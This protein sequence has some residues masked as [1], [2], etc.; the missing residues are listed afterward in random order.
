L[1]IL[2]A[3][4]IT[5]VYRT[6]GRH[7]ERIA[8]YREFIRLKTDDVEAYNNVAW[9]LAT[10]PDPKFRDSAQAVELARQAVKLA[11]SS[12]T[13]WN[14]LGAARYCGGDWKAAVAAL[15]KSMELRQGGDG[16]TWFFLAMAHWQLGDKK[17]AR[18]WYDQAVTWMDKNKPQDDELRRFR[19][20]AEALLGIQGPLAPQGK[21]GSARK[22][23]GRYS[24][25][26]AMKEVASP[27]TS[28]PDPSR[29]EDSLD[30]NKKGGR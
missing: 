18:R 19:A 29:G 9:E 30:G 23:W 17:Q 4:L 15:E 14:T 22:W 12:G 11:P 16:L 13:S 27:R 20:E 3:G 1:I 8:L 5:G 21:E 6:A 26:P 2:F 25:D 24:P 10:C 7:K 28:L